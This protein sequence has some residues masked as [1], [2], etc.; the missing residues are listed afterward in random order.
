VRYA[1]FLRGINVS[2]R[3]DKSAD[4]IACMEELG[5]EEPAVFRA[6]GNLVF[7]AGAGAEKVAA[8]L[9]KALRKS[10]GFEV[11]VFLRSARQVSAIAAHQP[12]PAKHLN[13]AKGKLQVALLAGK[14]SAAAKERTLALATEEDLLAIRGSELYWLP[15]GGTQ[16]SELGMKGIDHAIGPMTM[17][18]KGTIEAIV[19]KYFG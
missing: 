9:E 17:R 11:P 13:A 12:F 6:S 8:K 16:G 3:R 18:T 2:N 5:F 19:E 1:A 14:P 7:E 15:S 10:L 4:L